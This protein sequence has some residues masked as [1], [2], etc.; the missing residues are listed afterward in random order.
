M[1]AIAGAERLA[2]GWSEQDLARQAFLTREAV[3]AFE[4]G[5]R[6]SSL[7]TRT[8]IAAAFS[9]PMPVV[10]Q[11]EPR[12][13]LTPDACREARRLLGWSARRLGSEAGVSTSAIEAFEAGRSHTDP[14]WF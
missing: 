6:K 1:R 2:R 11:A 5:V 10:E 4:A 7:T 9:A 14:Q 12:R 3:C 13:V 8:A